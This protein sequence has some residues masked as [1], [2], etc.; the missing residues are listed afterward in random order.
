M[1]EGYNGRYNDLMKRAI[2]GELFYLNNTM[3]LY[4]YP[5]ELLRSFEDVYVL[6]YM[7]AAQTQ[8]YY[9]DMKGLK[10]DY[11]G[12]RKSPD[13]GYIFTERAEVPEYARHL[14][15]K[16]HI[17]DSEKMNSVGNGKYAL[18][19]RWFQERAEQ[20]SVDKLKKNVHNFFNNTSGSKASD[21]LWATYAASREELQGRYKQNFL[22]FNSRATNNYRDK[23]CLAYLVNVFMNPFEYNFF[24][25]QGVQPDQDGYALSVMVQWV[26]RSAIREG[27]DIEIYIPSK[28][29]RDLLIAWC[30]RLEKGEMR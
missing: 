14:K 23:T 30:D 8:R 9:F 3:L 26:W 10:Y 13:G 29:M 28:R 11:I 24:V 6:T 27:K 21:R 22:S 20:D 12:T 18:S 4:S 1:D 2:T 25:S 17:V 19:M 16:I 15:E 5:I 7:F